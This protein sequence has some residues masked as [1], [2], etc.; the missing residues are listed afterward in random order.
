MQP[1]SGRTEASSVF[2]GSQ[3]LFG[4]KGESSHADVHVTGGNHFGYRA[5]AHGIGA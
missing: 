4:E 2:V 3:V 1:R 5:G